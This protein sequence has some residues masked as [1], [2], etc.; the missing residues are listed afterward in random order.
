M[1]TIM[2]IVVTII[3]VMIIEEIMKFYVSFD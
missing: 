2:V 3:M 1:I